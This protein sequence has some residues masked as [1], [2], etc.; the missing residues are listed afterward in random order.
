MHRTNRVHASNF[1]CSMIP[2]SNMQLSNHSELIAVMTELWELLD[3]LA[4]VKPGASLRRPPSDTGIHRAD[5]F[6]SSAAL[7]AGFTPEAITVM[8][9]LPYLHDSHPDMGQ[10]AV[11]ICGSTFPLSYLDFDE[12][13][14]A[15]QR[16]IFADPENLVLPS[17]FRL[18][19]QEVNGREY[20]YDTEKSIVFFL[21]ERL[22]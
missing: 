5:S 18:T 3:M 8:S 10:R 17:V 20:I 6:N 19:W 12:E 11:E 7:A 1:L 22:L 16:E 9:T 14:F 21:F 13:Q 15:D 4:I 2:S